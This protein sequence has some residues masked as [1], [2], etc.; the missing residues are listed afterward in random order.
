MVRWGA[1]VVSRAPALPVP[2]LAAVAVLAA[3]CIDLGGLTGLRQPLEET[4]VYGSSGPKL[5][6][7]EI[8]GPITDYERPGFIGAGTEG[9]VARVREQL[10]RAAREGVRGILL[11]VDSPGGGASASE[12]I[13]RQLLAFKQE[14]GIP[15]VAHFMGTA[16]SGGYYVAMAADEI[17]AYPTTVTG[18]IGVVAFGLNFVGLMEKLGI[19]SQTFTSGD[20]K[21]AG[22]ALRRMRPDEALHMQSIIDDMHTRFRE[23]VVTGRPKLEAESVVR[24]ADGRVYSAPQALEHGLID[25]IGDIE[26]SVDRLEALAGIEGPSR[27]VSYH[28]PNEWRNNL[29]TRAPA[30][31][32]IQLD[33]SQLFGPLPRPGFH[34]LWIP[35]VD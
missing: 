14:R 1:S 16:A 18:S 29:F 10:Q 20:F 26:D 7:L 34:Y 3:G 24:L 15:I 33:L 11:R 9:T 32:A 6:Q 13:Y 30:A 8:Q 35:G 5:L 23:V 28:R 2:A 25:A 27:V 19:E 17:R 4:V 31:P 12:V 22:S 21:D